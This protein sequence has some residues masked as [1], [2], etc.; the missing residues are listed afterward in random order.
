MFS[1]G[2]QPRHRSAGCSL[3]GFRK[4]LVL[5]GAKQAGIKGATKGRAC[6]EGV[7]AAHAASGAGRLAQACAQRAEK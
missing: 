5:S 2:D 4:H 7:A 6:P 3:R 1:P